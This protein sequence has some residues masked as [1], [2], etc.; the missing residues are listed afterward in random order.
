MGGGGDVEEVELESGLDSRDWLNG[1]LHSS[2]R[3]GKLSSLWDVKF[4]MRVA[5]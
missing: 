5:K 1:S 2:N 3:D 4:Q